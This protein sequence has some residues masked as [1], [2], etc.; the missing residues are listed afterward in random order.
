VFD[1]DWVRPYIPEV[2]DAG[3][4]GHMGRAVSARPPRASQ[5]ICRAW[6]CLA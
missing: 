1:F 4:L 6:P 3:G 5:A 2:A